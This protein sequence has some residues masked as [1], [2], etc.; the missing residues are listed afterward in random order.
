MMA[1]LASNP[2]ECPREAEVIAAVHAGQWAFVP[3]SELTRHVI[4]CDVCLEVAE[5][6]HRFDA[7]RRTVNR[8]ASV[9]SAA[10]VWWRAQ[11]R[12]RIDAAEVASH[13]LTVA[14]GVGAVCAAALAVLSIQWAWPSA[15]S[16]RSWVGRFAGDA[17]A[18]LGSVDGGIVQLGLWLTLG[19]AA[20]VLVPVVVFYALPED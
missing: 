16:V 8:G 3:G 19:L 17:T 6:A 9:P 2:T 15:P 7:E 10:R 18:M 14:Q 13:P 11:M 1:I 4:G 5:V 12:A 20:L